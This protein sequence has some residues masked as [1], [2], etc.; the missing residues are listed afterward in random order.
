MNKHIVVTNDEGKEISICPM[1]RE[2][3][4]RIGIQDGNVHEEIFLTQEQ[5]NDLKEAFNSLTLRDRIAL[6]C[7]QTEISNLNKMSDQQLDRYQLY[8]EK[9]WGVRNM[10]DL[11]CLESFASSEA[12][13]K[14]RG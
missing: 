14:A 2:N 6:E 7:L 10:I 9:R 1:K 3:K 11:I 8:L 13:L 5:F 12:F 4:I